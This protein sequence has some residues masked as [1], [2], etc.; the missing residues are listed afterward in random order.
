MKSKP[1]YPRCKKDQPSI[2]KALLTKKWTAKTSFLINLKVLVRMISFQNIVIMGEQGL[3][4][5]MGSKFLI[6]MTRLTN[7]AFILMCCSLVIF[8]KNLISST[9]R[10]LEHPKYQCSAVRLLQ[11]CSQDYQKGVFKIEWI[12]SRSLTVPDADKSQFICMHTLDFNI[13]LTH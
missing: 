3:L 11:G 9:T 1:K 12:S 6:K 8:I 5:L 7:I 10:G 4:L 2:W 13:F